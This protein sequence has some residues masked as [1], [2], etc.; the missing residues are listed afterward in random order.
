MSQIQSHR[1]PD[2]K[3]NLKMT[4]DETK[5]E[6]N[7]YDK[8]SINSKILRTRRTRGNQQHMPRILKSDNAV[9]KPLS[10]LFEKSHF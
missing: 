9:I 8:P 7:P 1:F 5:A 3:T 6:I 2:E 10:A 4:I